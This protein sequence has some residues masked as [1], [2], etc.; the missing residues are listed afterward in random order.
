MVLIEI[1]RFDEALPQ[2][3]EE[4]QRPAEERDMSADRLAAG[5]AGDRLVHDGLENRRRQVLPGRA[6]VDQRLDIGLSEDAAAR[7]DRVDGLVGR[8]ED[9]E[10]GRVGLQEVRHL[11]DEGACAAGADAV[12]ALLDIAALKIDDLRVLAAKLDGDVGHGGAHF[13]AGRDGDDLLDEGNAQ[14]LRER[15]SARTGD[16][17]RDLK[18]AER[19]ERLADEP[20]AGLLNLRVVTLVVREEKTVLSVQYCHLDGGGAD[21]YAE[22]VIIVV[23]IIPR[24]YT[25]ESGSCPP[26]SAYYKSGFLF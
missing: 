5:E 12:H 22:S 25:K 15:E 10:A 24:K 11:V 9:V 26:H 19:I 13:Q 8:G 3:V 23:H 1:Q 14:V 4:M 17:G 18:V 21:I 16:R 7:G 2:L 6:F 20:A